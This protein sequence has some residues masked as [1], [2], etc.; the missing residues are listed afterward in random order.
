YATHGQ[1]MGTPTLSRSAMVSQ[2]DEMVGEFV[3]APKVL[4]IEGKVVRAHGINLQKA[5]DARLDVPSEINQA[6]WTIK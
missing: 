2:L 1:R 5:Y 3:V 6:T 4:R